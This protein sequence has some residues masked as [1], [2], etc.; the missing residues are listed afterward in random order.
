MLSHSAAIELYIIP[1]WLCF[2]V[3]LHSSLN[4]D[5]DVLP[6]AICETRAESL[7]TT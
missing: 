4:V 6:T 7:F 3:H 1:L 2:A 5:L